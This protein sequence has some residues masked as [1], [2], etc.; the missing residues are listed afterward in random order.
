MTLNVTV[1]EIDLSSSQSKL[2]SLA[3]LQL[4]MMKPAQ[5]P[6]IKTDR[7]SVD[8][9][10]KSI[11]ILADYYLPGYRAGGP[12]RSL[13]NLVLALANE[14][15]WYVLTRDRDYRQEAP[16]PGLRTGEWIIT[17]TTNIFYVPRSSQ[18]PWT[19]LREVRRLRPNLIY[20][21]SFFSPRFSLWV[22]FAKR[23]GL[24]A[25]SHILIAPRGEF[26]SGALML[27]AWQKS[28]VLFVAR[29]FGILQTQYWHAS[30]KLEAEDIAKVLTSHSQQIYCA[31]NISFKEV[32]APA[33]RQ[34]GAEWGCETN[35]DLRICF[36]SRITPMKNLDYA[37]RV[38]ADVKSS[39]RFTIY[40]PKDGEQYWE[41]CRRLMSTLP[42]NVCVEVEGEIPYENVSECLARH[43][44]FFVPS[45]GENFG[46]VFA[47][48]LGAGLTI[49]T[50]DKTP[51]R[52]LAKY[53]V[54]FD[55]PL[56]D[57]SAF[58][59]VIENL[60]AETS[61]ERQARRERCLSHARKLDEENTSVQAHRDMLNAI[62]S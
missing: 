41:V 8:P 10:K 19:L 34:R 15:N 61:S 35:Y 27:K 31:R 28:F 62:L 17:P 50:S 43:D 42:Q 26:S 18:Y 21:N 2:G 49:L 56:A 57:P 59:E 22:L 7:K 46:H 58:T 32:P 3:K 36:L 55:L 60:A 52:R 33:S 47:E 40:G 44:L 12:V 48:A 14:Y 4:L 51:W 24:L 39:I 1:C 11:L 9:S 23:M 25:G 20:L 30:T 13:S 37:L 5:M 16:Y 53:G 45:R 29:R 6:E 38:L 54:G